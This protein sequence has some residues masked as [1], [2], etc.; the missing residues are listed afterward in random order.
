MEESALKKS[1]GTKYTVYFPFVDNEDVMSEIRKKILDFTTRVFGGATLY[2]AQGS[3]AQWG[4][5]LT[6]VLEILVE[7]MESKETR[8]EQLAWLILCYIDNI[9]T[10]RRKP[11][12]ET[13]WFSEQPI[14]LYKLNNPDLT[15]SSSNH[16]SRRSFTR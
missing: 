11:S 9:K 6:C 14:T 13:V 7:D 12:E 2:R 15:R 1:I 16:S 4:E 5:E 8:I 10:S 3:T